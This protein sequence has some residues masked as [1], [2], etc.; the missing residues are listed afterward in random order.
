MAW[1]PLYFITGISGSG[2][3]TVARELIK[4]GHIA[5]DSKVTKGI[6][7]FADSKGQPA[8]D[9]HP[10]DKDWLDIYKWTLNLPLLQEY[11]ERYK[12]ANAI[13]L[14][15][16]GNIRQH[17]ALAD[18]VLLLKVDANTMVERLNR[19]DRDNNFAKDKET[20]E[21][22]LNDLEFVQRSLTNA[23]AITIDATQPID[24]VVDTILENISSP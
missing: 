19:M 13:F 8:S 1:P 21:K 20:Q 18:K 5:L 11:L 17:W 6:F 4:R 24:S 23:G 16:R 7:H 2:K 9:Y 22:L 14:C 3:T 15:G 12:E 10:Q